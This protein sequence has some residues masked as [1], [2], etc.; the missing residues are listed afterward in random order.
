MVLTIKLNQI[1]LHLQVEFDGNYNVFGAM[2]INRWD[3]SSASKIDSAVV[4][5]LKDG[6]QV[7][8]IVSGIVLV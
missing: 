2:V 5:M 8:F 6:T 4:T 7:E 3:T 1:H